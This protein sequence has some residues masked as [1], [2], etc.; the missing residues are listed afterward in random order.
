MWTNIRQYKTRHVNI[1]KDTTIQ[2]DT[3]YGNISTIYN[4]IRQ[5][6]K[7]QYNII[8]YKTRQDNVIQ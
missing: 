6:K 7:T 5:Y 1:I 3:R 4:D 2:D 8:Q